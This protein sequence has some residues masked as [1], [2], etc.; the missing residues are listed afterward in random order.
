MLNVVEFL[1]WKIKIG[2]NVFSSYDQYIVEKNKSDL[3]C[4]LSKKACL[5][6]IVY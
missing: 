3:F 2:P 5:Y 4:S 1:E 6:S